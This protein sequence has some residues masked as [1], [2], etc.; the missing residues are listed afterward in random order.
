MEWIVWGMVFF[1]VGGLLTIA[2]LELRRPSGRSKK[3]AEEWTNDL[4]DGLLDEESH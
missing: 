1:G 4:F 2:L 3:S